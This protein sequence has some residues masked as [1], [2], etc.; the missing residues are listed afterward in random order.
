MATSAEKGLR[1][2]PAPAGRG[3][4]DCIGHTPLLR[5]RLF[6]PQAPDLL[7]LGKAEF[8]NPGGS[9]KDR[10][11]LRMVEEALRVGALGR[12]QILLD[13]TSGN[14]GVAYAMLGAALRFPVKLVVPGNV[15]EERRRLMLAYG[16]ELV[17][18]DPQEGSDGALLL[19]REIQAE[20][21][22][23]YFSPD[24]YN[25]PLNWR[26]HYE[27]TAIE[28]WEQTEGAVS[29]FLAG[30]GTSGTFVGTARR[31]KELNPDITCVSLQPEDA[32]HGL[33]GLKHMAS[34][35]VPGI[36]DA[37]LA[38]RNLA[39]PTGPAYDLAR[40][41]AREEG[42]LA[43]HS[44]GLALWGV[45]QL[46]QEGLSEGV[47]VLILPDGGARYLSAGLYGSR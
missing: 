30:L 29:V 21:P 23:R 7:V 40:R 5:L 15:G 18:S 28:I 47:A 4:A 45:E 43:G 42:I 25:N 44:S 17:L 8:M 6:E 13:S 36:Y 11:A 38:D 32:L 22:E 3:I 46:V 41:L 1:V 2:L 10:P 12:G 20:A 34:A 24:Q 37:T 16:A 26:S 33:E 31:L 27:T 14:T 35:I 9:V 39:G 19:C